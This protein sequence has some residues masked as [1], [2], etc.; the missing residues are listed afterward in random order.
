MEDKKQGFFEKLKSGLSKTKDRFTK[1]LISAFS[2]F[3][4][5]D[6]DFY[7]RMEEILISADLGMET[8]ESIL[9]SLRDKVKSDGL[10][11]PEEAL[12]SLKE[13]LKEIL[14]SVS[15]DLEEDISEKQKTVIL[16]IGVNGVGK[17]TTAAKLASL[18]KESG[19]KVLLSS[20]DTFRAG[21]VE[22]L[23]IWS[24]RVEVPIITAEANTDPSAV[25][26]DSIQSAKRRDTDVLIA[27]T[28]GRLHNK[29]DLMDELRKMNRII[30]KE[31]PE[32]KP[33]N[34]LIIDATTGQNGLLQAKEFAETM[35]LS[36]LIL[37]KMDGTAK[38]GIIF[39]II[40]E[41]KIPVLYMG[42]G[43]KE[44]DLSKFYPDVFVDALFS[45]D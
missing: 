20:C 30:L 28:A 23:K 39:P 35:D 45:E 34:L 32:A 37:T 7:E 19:K 4:E 17:T 40:H 8:T 13:I 36:G 16:L 42:L 1:D 33:M 27:D 5:I 6:E 31:F 10:R 29:K 18:Y 26:F 22:Q 41:L 24:E 44:T 38:G 15:D 3:S 11:K 43:E 14:H 21:A 12:D 2:I 25:L 9:D